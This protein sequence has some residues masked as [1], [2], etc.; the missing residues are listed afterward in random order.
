MNA[1]KGGGT[2]R[3]PI[4]MQMERNRPP[5]ARRKAR[6]KRQPRLDAASLAGGALEF[7]PRDPTWSYDTALFALVFPRGFAALPKKRM[8]SARGGTSPGPPNSWLPTPGCPDI[9]LLLAA[10][11]WSSATGLRVRRSA[12]D[13]PMTE[14]RL[15]GRR[16]ADRLLLDIAVG[17]GASHRALGPR[18]RCSRAPF[19]RGPVAAAGAADG[20]E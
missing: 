11:S 8:C 6:E 2:N 20:G 9:I 4:F 12:A 1:R 15:A 14:R 5:I 13:N 17:A 7:L 18:C 16:R 19:F 10:Y 3:S